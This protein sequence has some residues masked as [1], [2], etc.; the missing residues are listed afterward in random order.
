MTLTVTAMIEVWLSSEMCTLYHFVL[1]MHSWHPSGL[2][3]FPVQQNNHEV[4][5]SYNTK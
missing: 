3:D 5:N 2:G 4:Y 1:L